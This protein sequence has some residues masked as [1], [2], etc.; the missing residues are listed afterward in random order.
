[1][2]LLEHLLN[3]AS[4]Q[5]EHWILTSWALFQHA[6]AI[7]ASTI[8]YF[9]LNSCFSGSSHLSDSLSVNSQV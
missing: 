7:S 8:M 4:C 1:M 9:I 5:W 2:L 6:W 3:N